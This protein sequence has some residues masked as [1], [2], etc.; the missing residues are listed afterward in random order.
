M[1]FSVNSA[2]EDNA[3]NRHRQC[4]ATVPDGGLWSRYNCSV[5][6][7]FNMD[8]LE[9]AVESIKAG[10]EDYEQGDHGRLLA[11]VRGIPGRNAAQPRAHALHLRPTR[12]TVDPSPRG[13]DGQYTISIRSLN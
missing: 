13:G 8:L 5:G 9:N 6:R 7:N 3:N 10:V 2:V 1:Y 4:H 12:R 11:A